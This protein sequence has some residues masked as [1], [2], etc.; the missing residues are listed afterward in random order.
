MAAVITRA[1]EPGAVPRTVFFGLLNDVASDPQV[2]DLA[3]TCDGR[4]WADRGNGMRET[5]LR[6]PFR[7]PQVVREYAVQLCAQLGRRLDD[8]CPIADAASPDGIRVHAVIAPLVPQGAAISIRFPDRTMA[9]LRHLSQLGVF[10]AAWLPMFVGLVRRHATVLITGGTGV[11]K[12]TLLKALLAQCDVNERIVTVEEVRELGE[13]GRGDH[14]SLV[15]REANVEGVGAISLT[16]LVKATLRMRPDRVVLGH[17][18]NLANTRYEYTPN[19]SCD[20]SNYSNQYRTPDSAMAFYWS[21]ADLAPQE[22]R[23]AQFL[24]GVGNFDSQLAD[25]TVGLGLTTS[26]I[27]VDDQKTGYRET[28]GAHFTLTATVDNSVDLAQDLYGVTVTPTLDKGLSLVG[29][30]MGGVRSLDHMA[31]GDS[32]QLTWSV[33]VDDPATEISALQCR[34]AVTAASARP[35]RRWAVSSFSP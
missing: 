6:V 8:A 24:Y 9:S 14:V 10:P 22:S 3:V 19:P 18:A 34:V 5:V 21:E 15:T 28:G 33:K 23:K 20:F 31:K 35:V 25:A 16:D 11:G 7:S 2:T 12:T 29:E 27:Q 4:V 13:L 30:T 32:R 26:A 1:D 17:W